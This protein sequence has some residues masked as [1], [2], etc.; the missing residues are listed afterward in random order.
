MVFICRVVSMN[1][2]SRN[3]CLIEDS[4]VEEEEVGAKDSKV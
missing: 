1:E 4:G 3:K 2:A